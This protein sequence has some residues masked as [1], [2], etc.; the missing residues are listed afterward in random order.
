MFERIRGKRATPD[1]KACGIK[2]LPS[3][4]WH[5]LLLSSLKRHKHT[6]AQ[7]S[8]GGECGSTAVSINGIALQCALHYVPCDDN[9]QSLKK[10]SFVKG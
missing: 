3:D 1:E 5:P 6:H 7:E 10:V 9:V 4:I 2:E 8:E